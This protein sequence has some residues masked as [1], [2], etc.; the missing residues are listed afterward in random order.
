M[1]LGFDE[2]A[3]PVPAHTRKGTS[4]DEG[5]CARERRFRRR[6]LQAHAALGIEQPV[7]HAAVVRLCHELADTLHDLGPDPFQGHL[8]RGLTGFPALQVVLADLLLLR[9]DR[10]PIRLAQRGHRAE[11]TRQDL[12]HFFADARDAQRE[13]EARQI[14]AARA[15]DGLD[16]V[17]RGLLGHALEPCERV[18]PQAVKI[19]RV[20]DQ[21]LFD[22][23]VHQLLSEAFDIHG[24]PPREMQQGLLALRPAIQ[25]ARA[26]RRRFSRQPHHRG[27]AGRAALGH[28][29]AVFGPARAGHANAD[30]LR[31][32]VAGAPH[33]HGIPDPD[34]LAAQL[35]F[36]VQRGV[37]DRGAAPTCT[38]MATTSVV[39]SSA[40]YLWAMAKRGARET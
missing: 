9:G 22:Q 32:H 12:R 19:G 24:A 17:L 7:D 40:A 1:S 10:A 29:E 20:L 33:H 37:G 25:P 5:F 38:S 23:L 39:C 2:L 36:V 4:E 3:R 13:D 16:H 27:P 6:P 28:L 8:Q 30:D 26:A 15:L 35:V 14:H 21:I 18:L 34:V 11:V 31:D